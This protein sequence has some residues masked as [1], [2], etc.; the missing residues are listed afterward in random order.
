MQQGGVR[1]AGLLSFLGLMGSVLG[2]VAVV[3]GHIDWARI[4][5]R[6]TA[7]AVVAG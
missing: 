7:G 2:V 4:R 6:G 1:V 5:S 3:R